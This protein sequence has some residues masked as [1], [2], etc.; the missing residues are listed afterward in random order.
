MSV[1]IIVT[2]MRDAGVASTSELSACMENKAAWMNEW[3]NEYRLKR[4]LAQHYK[5]QFDET[6]IYNSKKEKHTQKKSLA[7]VFM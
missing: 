5:N 7:F 2:L 6:M 3:M 1:Y 4:L